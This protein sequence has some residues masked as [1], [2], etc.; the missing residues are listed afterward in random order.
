MKNMKNKPTTT[1][2][3]ITP[4]IA[5]KYLSTNIGHQRNVTMSHQ[6]H[7]KQQMEKG[8][9]LMTGEPI[10]F[11]GDGRLIDGQHRL[12]A[13]IAANRSIEFVITRG[14]PT[15][16]FVA[17]NRGKPRSNANIFA[18]HG[19]KN[20][21]ATASC[22]A[23]VLNYRRALT[24]TITSKDG[25]KKKGGSLNS[26]IRSSSADLIKEYDS[27]PAKYDDAIHIAMSAKRI[28]TM[29]ISSSVAALA[30]IDAGHTVHEVSDFWESV[31]VGAGLDEGDPILTLR[32]KLSFNSGSNAKLSTNILL[33]LCVKAWNAHIMGE[34][35]YQLKALDGEGVRKVL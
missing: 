15:D 34:R 9:W 32:N 5:E 24:T 20:H 33:M 4:Q 21:T 27:N 22:V 14:V 18:I 2:E 35:L 25:K 16:S 10:I 13:L 7:L 26:Y 29:S 12:R 1:I 23:N 30:M 3:L 28:C 19:A 8:Q 17:I 31:K 11:D 6:L